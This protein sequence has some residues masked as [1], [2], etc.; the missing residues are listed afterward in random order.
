MTV[1]PI[2]SALYEGRT[3]DAEALLAGA[4]E[5]DVFEAAAAG[6]TERMRELLDERP[7]LV[8]EWSSDGFQPL[9]LA[10]FFGQAGAVR[11]L[12]ERGADPAV[13]SKHEFV[14]VT[15]LHSAVAGEGAED[16]E[17]VDALLEGGAPVNARVEGG[18][19]PLHSAA[20]NGNEA[21]AAALLARG[22][23]PQA[24]ADGGKTPLDLARENGYEKVVQLAASRADPSSP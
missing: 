12:L 10:A 23:D 13:V 3:A 6:R 22:G 9:H 20:A 17:T 18:H 11:L 15:P 21:V 7:A 5:L 8:R 2:L 24:A 16:L 19:T 4:P 1:S 14:K